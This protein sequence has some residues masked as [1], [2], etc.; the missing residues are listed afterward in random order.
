MTLLHFISLHLLRSGRLPRRRERTNIALTLSRDHQGRT[1]L[2]VWIPCLKNGHDLSLGRDWLRLMLQ[3]KGQS[4]I[5]GPGLSCCNGFALSS[6]RHEVCVPRLPEGHRRILVVPPIDDGL[7]SGNGLVNRH[8]CRSVSH[9][10]TPKR[11]AIAMNTAQLSAATSNQVS[12]TVLPITQSLL[13]PWP[14]FTSG[15]SSG[16]ASL[17]SAAQIR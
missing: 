1:I 2:G 12:N 15:G 11:A 13:R 16:L 4:F 5:L 7:P 14:P 10:N 9:E 6:E 3:A 17:L 8:V